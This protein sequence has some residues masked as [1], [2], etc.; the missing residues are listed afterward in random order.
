M[1]S[2]I[3]F[4]Y[5]L[6]LCSAPAKAVVYVNSSSLPTNITTGCLGALTDN[7]SCDDSIQKLRPGLYY[8]ESALTTICTS[9]CNSALNSFQNSI[10]SACVGETY[11][12]LTDVGFV[13]IYTIPDVLRYQFNLSCLSSNSEFCN[14]QAA[15]AAG[16]VA[17]QSNLSKSMPRHRNK[18][19]INL[20]R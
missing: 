10:L 15:T 1:F 4:Y 8:P 20:C 12:S 3:V 13:P 19:F 7:I 14:V 11:D 9:S 2:Y 18:K 17:D 5:F 6:L 16:V